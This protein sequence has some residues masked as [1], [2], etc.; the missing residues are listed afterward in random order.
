MKLKKMVGTL[1]QRWA[2]T[3]IREKFAAV[4]FLFGICPVVAVGLLAGM[5]SRWN[6]E[7]QLKLLTAQMLQ[8]MVHNLDNQIQAVDRL[9]L[10]ITTNAR[11]LEDVENYYQMPP[12]NRIDAEYHLREWLVSFSENNLNVAG[13]YIFD[14]HGNIFFTKGSSPTMGYYAPDQAWYQ[15][16]VAMQGAMTLFGPHDEFHVTNRPQTVYTISH[17]LRDFKTR[18]TIG[19]L[20]IDLPHEFLSGV[21][22][23]MSGEFY[24][25]AEI[26]VLDE[27]G[28][29]VWANYTGEADRMMEELATAAKD[30]LTTYER[31][32]EKYFAVS[33]ISEVTGW[34]VLSLKRRSDV[35][36]GVEVA[37]AL[38]GGMIIVFVA[39]YVICLLY[40]SRKLIRPVRDMSRATERIKKGD[41]NVWLS[42]P[43]HGEIS[44]LAENLTDMAHHIQVLIQDQYMSSIL[45]RE[46]E[47]KALQNQITPHFLLNSLECVRGMAIEAGDDRLAGMVKAL[48][49]YTSYNI[50]RGTD[51]VTVREEFKHIHDYM[52]VQNCRQ[53]GKYVLEIDIPDRYMDVQIMKLILQPLLENSILHGLERKLGKGLV[54]V[55]CREDGS[56]LVFRIQDNGL[57]MSEEQ[58]HR[59]NERLRDP[60]TS[61][62]GMETD[63]IGV[64]NVN[65]RLRIGYGDRYGLYYEQADGGG[66]CVSMRIPV[67][68]VPGGEQA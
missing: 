48:A 55:S 13:A 64:E 58:I 62:D 39:V 1:L 14:G 47:L 11:I 40:I 43:R 41:F 29:V 17:A 67:N 30:G 9:A 49:T 63:R 6:V 35:F 52:T 59:I 18:R 15:K 50:T 61:Q 2:H 20:M 34:R 22:G 23:Q 51:F 53:N 38:F 44:T 56:D 25:D 57:G 46:A 66:I 5:F 19:V 68:F 16:T 36:A 32:G 31:G 65:S 26:Y 10:S 24:R 28:T 37:T 8:Q 3:G 45:R 27:N 42:F 33:D 4:F 60:N 7:E 21:F 54:C 12:L